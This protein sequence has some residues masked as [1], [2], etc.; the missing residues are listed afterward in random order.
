M[1]HATR[2]GNR[3]S[4]WTYLKVNGCR[5]CQRQEEDET[6][7]HVLSGGCEG[8]GRSKNNRYRTEMR[9]ILRKC[10]KLMSDINNSEGV[11]QA[12]KA[13]RALERPRRHADPRLQEEEEL[14][15]RQ[16][17]AGIIPEWHDVNNKRRKGILALLRIWTGDMMNLARIQMK[18]WVA[19]KNE[20]KAKV[21]RRWDSR[22]NMNEVFQIWKKRVRHEQEEQAEGI[23]DGDGRLERE[24]TYGN[25]HW[26]K[27]RAI[28]RI[29]KQVQKSLQ[30]GIG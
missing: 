24:K 17:M 10:G 21:Q 9:G 8:I 26:G 13:L 27:V 4:F 2:E 5:G 14:A 18:T 19:T 3:P 22:G 1:R 28:P 20:H 29:H 11:E 25:K 30:K 16:I 7:H 12:S 6:I 23:E 15:L